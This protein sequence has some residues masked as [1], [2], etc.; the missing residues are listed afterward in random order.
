MLGECGG[1]G[2][3]GTQKHSAPPPF[4][5]PL[6]HLGFPEVYPLTPSLIYEK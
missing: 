6:F 2:R 3:H 4:P 5:L 1:G